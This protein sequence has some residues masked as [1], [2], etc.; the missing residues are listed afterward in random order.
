MRSVAA[1]T[2]GSTAGLAM[3]AMAP[4]RT[5]SSRPPSSTAV[6]VRLSARKVHGSLSAGPAIAAVI[7][8]ASATVRDSGPAYAMLANSSPACS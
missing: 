6:V 7:T 8:A 2:S 3:R 5:P 1:A 4:M